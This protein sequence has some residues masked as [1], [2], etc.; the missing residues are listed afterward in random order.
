[1]QRNINTTEDQMFTGEM[2]EFGMMEFS[3]SCTGHF[4]EM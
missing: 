1:M 4:Q 2:S 3:D